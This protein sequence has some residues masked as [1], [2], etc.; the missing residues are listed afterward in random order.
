MIDMVRQALSP[1]YKLN[2]SR[3]LR[4]GVVWLYQTCM[5]IMEVYAAHRLGGTN[6]Y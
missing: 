4:H 3:R 5:V 2:H 1:G 6:S